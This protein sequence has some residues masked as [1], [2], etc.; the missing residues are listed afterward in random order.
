MRSSEFRRRAG[1]MNLQPFNRKFFSSADYFS[2]LGSGEIGGKASGLVELAEFMH[3]IKKAEKLKNLPIR[4]PKTIILSTE[5]FRAFLK[6]N[7]LVPADLIQRTDDE[8]KRIFSSA[9][10]PPE[11]TGELYA[12][13][14]AWNTPLAIRSSSIL[15]DRM[16]APFAGVYQTKMIPNYYPEG[17]K[18]FRDLVEAVKLV[19]ASTFFEEARQYS[20]MV[21]KN[22]GDEEMAVM[23]QQ[24]VGQ[25]RERYFF[26]DISGVMQSINFYSFGHGAPDDGLVHLAFG[27]GQTIVSDGISWSYCPKYPA[28]PPPFNGPDDILKNTQNSFWAIRMEPAQLPDPLDVFEFMQRLPLTHPAARGRLPLVASV[29]DPSMGKF[30][31]G[32][33]RKGFVVLDFAPLLRVARVP[34]NDYLSTI[35]DETEKCSGSKVEMEFAANLPM[36]EDERGEVV[37]LQMRKMRAVENEMR[38]TPEEWEDQRVVLRSSSTLGNGKIERLTHVLMIHPDLFHISSSK[39]IA[40]EIGA[41]NAYCQ[42]KGVRYLLLSFGRLGTSDPWLGVPVQWKDITNAQVIVESVKGDWKVDLSFGSHFFHNLYHLGV[43]YFAIQGREDFCDWKYFLGCRIVKKKSYV[44]L[45]ETTTP[46]SV[47]TDGI[48]RRGI[49][50]RG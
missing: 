13:A 8:L 28:S 23:I 39:I 46:L 18:R 29:Y 22:P 47:K 6:R 19:Y 10:M 41:L 49:I 16:D 27:L 15:E 45:L 17:E 11:Y 50:L 5:L 42:E 24:V 14:L 3:E 26:P 36:H 21:G 44:R 31:P 1:R 4:I 25:S 34:I 12:I 7:H 9:E 33:G 40:Q 2:V 20:R 35:L 37:L 30:Y 48:Q 32:T 38:I 43:F